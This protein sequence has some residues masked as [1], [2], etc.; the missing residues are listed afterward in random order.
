MTP[1]E[2]PADHPGRLGW[3]VSGD[4]QSVELEIGRSSPERKRAANEVGFAIAHQLNGPLTALG[5]IR[6][7]T[8]QS[9]Y[10]RP[11]MNQMD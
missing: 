9:T 8:V 3:I 5:L 7:W 2:K 11:A 1:K 10:W 6:R 4:E